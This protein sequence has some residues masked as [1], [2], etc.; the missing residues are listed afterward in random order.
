MQFLGTKGAMLTRE[1]LQQT[2]TR[3]SNTVTGLAQSIQGSLHS[4]LGAL[5][6]VIHHIAAGLA[7]PSLGEHYLVSFGIQT[8][9][10]M[11]GLLRRIN[12]FTKDFPTVRFY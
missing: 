2:A 1:H 6:G 10:K 5:S 11:R 4:L 9:G 3:C 8:H 7:M 12:R